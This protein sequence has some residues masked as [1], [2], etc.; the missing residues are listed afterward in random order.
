ML[1][2][3]IAAELEELSATVKP[4]VRHSSTSEHQ[5]LLNLVE[6]YGDDTS[7]MFRDRK[8]NVWQKTEGEIKRM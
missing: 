6:K 1:R 7:K 8:M 5:W 2:P 4:V 3:G